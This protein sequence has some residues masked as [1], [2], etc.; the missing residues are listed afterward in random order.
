MHGLDSAGDVELD[1]DIGQIEVGQVGHAKS[2]RGQADCGR[3]SY[4]TGDLLLALF[5]MVCDVAEVLIAAPG[6]SV[7]AQ[8][9]LANLRQDVG[10]R[11]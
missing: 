3:S 8:A 1:L 4:G 11:R 7:E 10:D 9:V 5:D 6:I 2:E